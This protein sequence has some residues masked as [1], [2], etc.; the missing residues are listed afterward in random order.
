MT[1]SL[2]SGN[3]IRNTILLAKKA[4]GTL[5]W[6]VSTKQSLVIW[7]FRLVFQLSFHFSGTFVL[8]HSS[9]Q[10]NRKLVLK[11]WSDKC[12][13]KQIGGL[14]FCFFKLFKLHLEEAG[15]RVAQH[16]LLRFS[17]GLT[18]L[19]VPAH[20]LCSFQTTNACNCPKRNERGQMLQWNIPFP[21]VG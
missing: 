13:W 15:L 12:L 17:W 16:P 4:E 21:D 20:Y 10:T 6:P 14:L 7:I 5:L 3:W 9:K 19:A 1:R 11:L 18:G 8:I 2:F